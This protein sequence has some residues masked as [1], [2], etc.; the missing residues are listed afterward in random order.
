MGKWAV[1]EGCPKLVTRSVIVDWVKECRKLTKMNGISE[2]T[3]PRSTAPP[4]AMA[5]TVAQKIS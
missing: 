2:T 4:T 3:L 1:N 5:Q